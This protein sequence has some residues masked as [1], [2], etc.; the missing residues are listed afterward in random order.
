MYI[1]VIDAYS[2]DDQIAWLPNDVE[3]PQA[4]PFGFKWTIT[5]VNAGVT[6]AVALA[7]STYAGAALDITIAFRERSE[8]IVILGIS[9]F[10]LGFAAGPLVWGP[11]S[12]V[13]GRRWILIVSP[14]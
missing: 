8:E 6:L 11:M 5:G 1:A 14:Q 10:V 7:S 13:Y 2:T 4:F 12:E 3:D 9:L